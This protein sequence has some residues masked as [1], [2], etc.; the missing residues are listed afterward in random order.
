MLNL[1]FRIVYL[2]PKGPTF[3]EDLYKEIMRRNPEKG[4]SQGSR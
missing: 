2:D 4:G 1:G 3:F